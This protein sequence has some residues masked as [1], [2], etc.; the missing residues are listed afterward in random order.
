MNP[1]TAG[2]KIV[3][4]HSLFFHFVPHKS[5]DA[6]ADICCICYS[7]YA[8]FFEA[9]REKMYYALL[10]T[11][12]SRFGKASG[13]S[14]LLL[15]IERGIRYM[16]GGLRKPIWCCRSLILANSKQ[17]NIFNKSSA[18]SNGDQIVTT[19]QS[20]WK[21]LCKNTEFLTLHVW[22]FLIKLVGSTMLFSLTLQFNSI[23]FSLFVQLF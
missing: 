8:L 15:F 22:S 17:Y 21:K 12:Q 6:S 16:G 14:P 20:F 5:V 1:L 4:I 11:L 9:K 23:Q 3:S 19:E 18:Y 13:K 10:F 7:S 2:Y